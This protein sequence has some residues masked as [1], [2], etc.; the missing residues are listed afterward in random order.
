MKTVTAREANQFFSKV[1]AEAEAGEEIVITRRGRPVA[2]LRAHDPAR[3]DPEWRAKVDRIVDL[4]KNAP[5][6]GTARRVSRDEIYE[7]RL[8][9]WL[10][11]TPTS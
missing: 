7:E 11:S 2:T 6:L 10:D 9:K 3:D 1:L 8:G 5:L 4:M